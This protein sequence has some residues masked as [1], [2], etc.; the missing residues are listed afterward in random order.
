[1]KI[2]T[3]E[4]MRNLDHRATT[5]FGVPDPFLMENA[6]QAVY[7]GAVHQRAGNRK[8][9][10]AAYGGDSPVFYFDEVEAPA[11]MLDSI[12]NIIKKEKSDN[13]DV[14]DD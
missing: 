14:K 4:E 3:V 11:R 2:A 7:P 9:P 12:F 5:G 10:T 13:E 8:P 1:M 6:G